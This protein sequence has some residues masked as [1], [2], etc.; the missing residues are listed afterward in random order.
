MMEKIEK[1]NKDELLELEK[2][3][4]Y[5]EEQCESTCEKVLASGDTEE[6]ERLED[7]L[8]ELLKFDNMIYSKLHKGVK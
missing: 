5:F 7:L 3:V 6:V 4:L 2:T 8:N 1:M